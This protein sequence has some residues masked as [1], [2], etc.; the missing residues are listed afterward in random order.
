MKMINAEPQIDQRAQGWASIRRR[1]APAKI[2]T[3]AQ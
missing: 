1:Q 3:L 2:A